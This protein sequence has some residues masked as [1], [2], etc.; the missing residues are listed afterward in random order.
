MT[1]VPLDVISG[2]EELCFNIKLSAQF[3][4]YLAEIFTT[5]NSTNNYEVTSESYDLLTLT[6]DWISVVCWC[7]GKS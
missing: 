3:F 1:C 2:R 6:Y 7:A 5:L 4:K